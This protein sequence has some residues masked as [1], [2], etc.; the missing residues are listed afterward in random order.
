M[1]ND[2]RGKYIIIDS[3]NNRTHIS[4][5][6][7][8]V[9]TKLQESVINKIKSYV[10]N[11]FPV[12]ENH[13]LATVYSILLHG[14]PGTGKTTICNAV[15]SELS[16]DL[17][18]FNINKIDDTF[19]VINKCGSMKSF[20]KIIAIN[21][22]DLYYKNK[23]AADN[24]SLSFIDAIH[25]LLESSGKYLENKDIIVICTTNDYKY[26][27]KHDPATISRFK[28]VVEMPELSSAEAKEF[29]KEYANIILANNASMINDKIDK[30]N[31]LSIRAI[32]KFVTSEATRILEKKHIVTR[33]ESLPDTPLINSTST[34]K[35][36]V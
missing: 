27:E 14:P 24:K 15:A 26:I 36:D 8:L 28:D 5:P 30:F 18:N 32:T 17:I 10:E 2:I 13:K 19:K 34:G 12:L 3:D 35:K 29:A 31:S 21:E 20:K 9:Q 4:T 23:T 25:D 7:T 6:P 16:A 11:V 22:F 1:I 33:H